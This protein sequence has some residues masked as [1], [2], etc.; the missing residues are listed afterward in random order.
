MARRQTSSSYLQQIAQRGKGD[1][2]NLP[3]LHPPRRWWPG[4]S[5]GDEAAALDDLSPAPPARTTGPPVTAP[6]PFPPLPVQGDDGDTGRALIQPPTTPPPH[7]GSPAAPRADR[8]P[9]SVEA[10]PVSPLE[11]FSPQTMPSAPAERPDVSRTPPAEPTPPDV[12]RAAALEPA[13]SPFFRAAAPPPP[14]APRPPRAE[15]ITG[16]TPAGE[17]SRN[18]RRGAHRDQ[19]PQE[20]R[21]PRLSAFAPAAPRSG[22]VPGNA[23]PVAA[24]ILVPPPPATPFAERDVENNVR[25]SVH[26]GAIEVRIEPPAAAAVP[27][28]ARPAQAA[29]PGRTPATAGTL[30]RG[31]TASYGLRQG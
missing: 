31:F 8:S 10:R 22:R 12:V 20:R 18:A 7:T 11:T 17:P 13:H 21:E 15:E 19:A 3:V 26:I 24:T 25:G 4:S 27:P 23:A 2:G 14:A 6:E 1:D 29:T 28:P 30:A 9:R 5:G 16:T